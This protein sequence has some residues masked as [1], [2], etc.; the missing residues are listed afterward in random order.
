MNQVIISQLEKALKCKDDKE[1][2]LRVEVLVDMLKEAPEPIKLPVNLP[3]QSPVQPLQP[4]FSKEPTL[5]PPY[6]VTSK[7]GEIPKAYVVPK[8]MKEPRINGTG[9]IVSN[10]EQVQYFSPKGT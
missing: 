3:S 7:T 6:K 10:R 9:P 1:L 8:N 2:R 4:Y 5:E